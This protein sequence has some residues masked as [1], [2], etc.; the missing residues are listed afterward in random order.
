MEQDVTI[1]GITYPDVEAVDY[2]DKSG[3]SNT[4]LH[5][6]LNG[7]EIWTAPSKY[8]ITYDEEQTTAMRSDVSLTAYASISVDSSG[9]F[10][11]GESMDTTAGA[12]ARNSYYTTHPIIYYS[13]TKAYYKVNSAKRFVTN[14]YY[15]YM[16]KCIV[17]QSAQGG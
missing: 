14:I 6:V 7:T 1:N 12:Y 16:Q 15:Y 17:T 13:S 2:V 10:V 5:L 9:N 3:K 11:L 8:I 4:L